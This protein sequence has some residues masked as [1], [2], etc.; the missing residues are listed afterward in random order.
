MKIV[1]GVKLVMLRSVQIGVMLIILITTYVN[2]NKNVRSVGKYF[3]FILVNIPVASDV[4][5]GQSI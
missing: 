3:I 4:V 1:N 2:L 5:V